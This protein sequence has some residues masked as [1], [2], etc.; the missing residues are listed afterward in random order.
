MNSSFLKLGSGTLKGFL[1]EA[2]LV[3]TGL[4]TAVFL[5]RRLGPEGYGLFT[6]ATTIVTWIEWSTTSIFSRTT[7]KFVS[8]A[9][10]WRPVGTTVLQQHLLVSS[11]AA[12][13]L[14]L[15]ADPIA[16]LMGEPTFTTYLLL[17][18]LEIPLFSL[19]RAHRNIL[20]GLGAFSGQAIAGASRLIAR[21]L[22]IVLFVK[23]GFSLLGAILG[24]VGASLVELLVSRLYVRPSLLHRSCFPVK[25]LW[26]YAIPLTLFSL[27]MRFY[28]KLDLMMLKA[29]GG[30][31]QLAGIYG[32]A[33]SLSLLPNLFALSFSPVLLSNVSRI[34]RDGDIASAKQIS[35][36][37][38]RLV[39]LMFPFAAMT[40]GAAL[41]IVNFIFGSQYLKAAPLLAVLIFGAI[42]QLMISVTTAILIAAGKPTWTFALTGPLLPLVIIGHWLLIP[43]MGEMGASVVTTVLTSVAA[44]ATVI[45]VYYLWQIF[46]PLITLWRTSLVCV[47]VYAVAAFLPTPGLWL[48]LKLGALSLLIPLAFLVLG[49]FSN[50]EISLIRSFIH[51]PAEK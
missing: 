2:L 51:L 42:A 32:A 43:Q 11:I 47:I 13:L 30:T 21:L 31:A 19:A 12:F 18:S 27:S 45:A 34:L 50:S 24:S 6:L 1:A 14:C 5:T 25:Q 29:L 49:E 38:M 22:L 40:A 46:P 7:I 3:P 8:E 16:Q 9:L 15:L 35:Q 4:L 41:G 48:L 39:L 37:A 26:N 17:F 33:Q 10:D 20:N 36:Q 44:I 28:E 23:L